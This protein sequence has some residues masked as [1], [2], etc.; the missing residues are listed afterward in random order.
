MYWTCSRHA[1]QGTPNIRGHAGGLTETST[2]TLL[3]GYCPTLEPLKRQAP[4]IPEACTSIPTTRATFRKRARAF[5]V[6]ELLWNY[7]RDVSH[8]WG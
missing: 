3:L 7:A 4:H 1:S 2:R 5:V 6:V 8:D